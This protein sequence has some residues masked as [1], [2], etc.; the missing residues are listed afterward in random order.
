MKKYFILIT[1]FALV[2]SAC[3][4]ERELD[5]TIFIPD[6]ENIELPAYTEWGYNSFGANYER[7]YFVV[8]NDIVPCKILYRNDS[9]QFF[10]NG[11]SSV[12]NQREP[13]TLAFIFPF[14]NIEIY[15]DL[16]KLHNTLI[17]LKSDDCV[18]KMINGNDEKILEILNGKLH[19]K[20]TQLLKIDDVPNRIIISGIF[21]LNFLKNDFPQSISDGRFDLG[22]TSNLFYSFQN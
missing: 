11:I 19:F 14:E 9:L 5:K 15:T 1:I 8:S 6:E 10:L 7:G 21:E 3:S 12:N 22:I 16:L 4:S 18:V 2:L 20:R 13:M 17:D